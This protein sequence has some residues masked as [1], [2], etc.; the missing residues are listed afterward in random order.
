MGNS[1]TI[2]GGPYR[3]E[4]QDAHAQDLGG[5]KLEEDRN[6]GRQ[7]EIRADV[8]L[9]RLMDQ[10]HNRASSTKKRYAYLANRRKNHYLHL[11]EGGV[12]KMHKPLVKSK[13][14]NKKHSRRRKF[15]HRGGV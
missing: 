1:L 15:R 5:T 14:F 4:R 7:A 10:Q 6:L 11:D 8:H 3:R 13:R 2:D 9:G 12:V